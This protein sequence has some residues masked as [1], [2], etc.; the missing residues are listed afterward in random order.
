MIKTFYILEKVEQ[1]LPNP[2]EKHTADSKWQFCNCG[3]CQRKRL[4]LNALPGK[5][6]DYATFRHVGEN[7]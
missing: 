1:T 6:I 3:T 2:L 5:K 7:Y 4:A